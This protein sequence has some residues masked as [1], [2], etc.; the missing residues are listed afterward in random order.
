MGLFSFYIPIKGRNSIYY[1]M[2]VFHKTV[3]LPRTRM[4]SRVYRDH[5]MENPWCL[6]S[7][8]KYLIVVDKIFLFTNTKSEHCEDH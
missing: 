7:P 3:F 6:S 2:G 8:H 4:L 5:G 1:A